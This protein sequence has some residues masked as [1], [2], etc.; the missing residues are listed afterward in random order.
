M[1]AHSQ[2]KK[3]DP[4]LH[5]GMTVL[6]L[7]GTLLVTVIARGCALLGPREG[8]LTHRS[9]TKVFYT[10]YKTIMEVLFDPYGLLLTVY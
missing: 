10:A 6:R 3:A 9:R 8:S 4:S 5:F 1:T 2:R 7:G